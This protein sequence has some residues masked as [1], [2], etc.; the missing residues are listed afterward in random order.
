MDYYKNPEA[1]AK[2]FL[3]DGWM[4]TGDCQRTRLFLVRLGIDGN[5]VHLEGRGDPVPRDDLFILYDG[6]T[7][8][9]RKTREK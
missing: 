9:G 4:R 8:P 5:C 6:R 2:V 3:P 7:P 1:T